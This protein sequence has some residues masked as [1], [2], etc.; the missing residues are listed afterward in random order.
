MAMPMAPVMMP[1]MPAVVMVSPPVTPVAHLHD[2]RA[3]LTCIGVAA[4]PNRPFDCAGEGTARIDY[5]RG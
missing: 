4:G 2:I 5:G 1:P 3:R